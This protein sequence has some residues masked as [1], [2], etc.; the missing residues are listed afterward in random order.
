MRGCIA[1]VVLMLSLCV[2]EAF[3]DCSVAGP[4]SIQQAPAKAYS[5]CAGNSVSG[6]SGNSGF[7]SRRA[8]RRAAR[9]SGLFGRRSGCGG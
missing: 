1:A 4:C 8:E 5:T 7:F 9:G 2:A 6:C 3:A